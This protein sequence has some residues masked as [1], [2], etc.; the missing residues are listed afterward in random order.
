MSKRSRKAGVVYESVDSGVSRPCRAWLD[1][2][3]EPPSSTSPRPPVEVVTFSPDYSGDL[4]LWGVDWQN[5]GL[6]HGLL[7][8]LVEWQDTFDEHFDAFSGWDSEEVKASWTADAEPLAEA[9]RQELGPA[10]TVNVSLW[11]NEA[12]YPAAESSE[13]SP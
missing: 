4:P 1:P 2:H 7:V 10:V 8:R 11:P 3:W 12:E 6:S 9:V 13:D 5:P